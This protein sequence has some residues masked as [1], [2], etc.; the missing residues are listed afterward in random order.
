MATK[1]TIEI[2]MDYL[3]DTLFPTITVA[4]GYNFTLQTISFDHQ[5]PQEMAAGSFPALFIPKVSELVKDISNGQ[6]QSIASVRLWGVVKKDSAT[7]LITP[8]ARKLISDLR[9]CLYVDPIQ[10]ER[11]GFT[12]VVVTDQDEGEFEEYSYCMVEVEFSYQAINTTP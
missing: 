5:S 6:F 12:H 11:V 3:K 9:K 10:G 8:E 7:N 2:L 4:N 1:S